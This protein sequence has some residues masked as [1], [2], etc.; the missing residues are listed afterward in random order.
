MWNNNVLHDEVQ[1]FI[2]ACRSEGEKIYNSLYWIK[3]G[4]VEQYYDKS[5]LMPLVEYV[6]SWCK[7][8]PCI[9]NSFLNNNEFSA[10]VWGQDFNVDDGIILE[11]SI[12]A[13]LFF[14]KYLADDKTPD[15]AIA[16]SII[17]DTV[18][19]QFFYNLMLLW[20]SFKAIEQNQFRF[21]VGY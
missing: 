5:R 15:N 10:S 16:L 7:K 6:P 13:E 8:I 3:E 12:C 19:D 20:N 9:G 21:H 11:P 14:G 18:L 1:L 4:R 2:G 17:N